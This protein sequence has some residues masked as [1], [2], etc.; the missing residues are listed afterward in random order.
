MKDKEHI[1]DKE[2]IQNYS[3]AINNYS[4]TVKFYSNNIKIIEGI[5]KIIYEY[6][7][8]ISSFQKKLTHIRK[9]LIK[10]LYQEEQKNFSFSI[11]NKYI[12][13]IDKFFNFQIESMTN[14]IQKINKKIIEEQGNNK[15]DNLNI[16]NQNKSNLQDKQIKMEKNFIEYDSEYKNYKSGLKSIEEDVQNYYYNL[17]RKTLK[18]PNIKFNKI[19][20]EANNIHDSFIKIHKK[21]GENNNKYF[22][23]Y[24]II[25]KEIEKLLIDKENYIENNINSFILILQEQINSTINT[26]KIFYS[27]ENKEINKEKNKDFKIFSE[28]N[29]V[30][31][32]TKYE[33]KKY[34]LKSLKEKPV[35]N[36]ISKENKNVLKY[37]SDELGF[38]NFLD[39]SAINLNEDDIFDVVK[40]FNGV[41]TYIDTSEYDLNLEKIKFNIRKFTNKLLLFG[42]IKKEPKEFNDLTPIN[43]EEINIL[44]NYLPKNRIYIMTFLQKINNFR[45]LGIFEIPEREY[46]IIGNIFKLILDCISK[47]KTEEDYSIIKLLIILSQTFYI[48]KEGK[49]NYISERLKGNKFLSETESFT[50]YIRSCIKKELEKSNSKTKGKISE[51]HKK[52]MIFATILPFC[53][54]LKEMDIS[55]EQLIKMVQNLS[56]EYELNEEFVNIINQSIEA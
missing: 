43:D 52:E 21:F 51:N 40:F 55:K 13:Y 4:K 28:N 3:N 42:L 29:L 15:N 34:K 24:D 30:K 41:F 11:Y 25:M 19:L 5:K 54:Y 12:L 14:I 48:N 50:D 47:E 31:L 36:Y 8:S 53:N 23:Y 26:L 7:E 17:R 33:K 56:K 32:V 39:A 38:E 46:E 20:K 22:E 6:K 37:L 16:F 35:T 9:N 18:D 49:K 10:P 45:T 2:Y 27:E 1:S 44:Q